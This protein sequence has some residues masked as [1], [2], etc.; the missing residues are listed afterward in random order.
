VAKLLDGKCAVITGGGRGM[1]RETALSFARYGAKVVV[2]DLGT[3][4]EGSGVDS[5]PANEVV[6]EIE[7]TGGVAVANYDNVADFN[8]AKN[9]IDSCVNNFGKIDILVN[10]AGI[11]D[12]REVEFWDTTEETWDL[13]IGVNLNGTF[14]TIRH[15]LGYMVK[16]K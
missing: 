2:N 1:G 7:K 13:V 10:C 5:S 15:A 8:A 16:Q 9:M 12:K 14:N 6:A 4:T 3:S 11:G